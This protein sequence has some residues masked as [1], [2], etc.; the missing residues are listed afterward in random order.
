MSSDD[1]GVVMRALKEWVFSHPHK[2]RPFLSSWAEVLR[3]SS[4]GT[5]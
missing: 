2:D 5:R 4:I 3:Q 1:E